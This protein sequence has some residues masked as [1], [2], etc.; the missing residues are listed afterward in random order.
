MNERTNFGQ[1]I[2][3]LRIRHSMRSQDLA[4]RV[5]ISSAYL[6][7]LEHGVRLNPDAEVMLKIVKVLDLTNEESA[8]IYDMYA[9]ATGR[10][11]PDIELYIK[12]SKT[13]QSALRYACNVSAA[14]EVWE[15]F[16]EQLK[17]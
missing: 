10:I 9:A 16:I 14:D 1:F 5:G 7:Q 6:S 8:K 12:E 4:R 2:S 15:R 17:K 3:N 13:V 11:S